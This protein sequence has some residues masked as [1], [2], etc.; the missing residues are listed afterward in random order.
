MI[1]NENEVKV[2]LEYVCQNFLDVT[3]KELVLKISDH[4]KIKATV[5]YQGNI[6]DIDGQFTLSYHNDEIVFENIDGK[7]EYLFLQLN[8]MNVLKQMIRDERFTYRENACY[9]RCDLP[10][11]EIYVKE[12]NVYIEVKES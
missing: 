3:V 9:F 2:W 12:G 6:L 8:M 5:L 1:L 4:V 7:V 11:G 10:I